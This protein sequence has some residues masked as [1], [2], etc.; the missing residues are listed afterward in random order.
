[1]IFS[2]F[3]VTYSIHEYTKQSNSYFH[4]VNLQRYRKHRKRPLPR[5]LMETISYTQTYH[6]HHHEFIAQNKNKTIMCVT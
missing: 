1:V 4:V 5:A 2:T 3:A 6:H